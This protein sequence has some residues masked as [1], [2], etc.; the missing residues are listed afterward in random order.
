VYTDK[1]LS[2]AEQDRLL[3]SSD[4]IVLK[5]ANSS[6]ILL[7]EVTL[8]LHQVAEDLPPDKQKLLES[9]KHREEIFKGK[10]ILIA[11]DDMRNVYAL[12]SALLEKGST[13]YVG[14]T[15]IEALN[16]LKE[17]PDVDIVLMDIMMPEMDGFEAI[18]NIRE[19][20]HFEELPIIALTAKAMKGDREKC[21]EIG[22]TDYLSKP[23]DV[24]QLLSLL[25]VWIS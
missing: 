13:I 16:Q 1:E 11:D 25:R 21:L 23:I 4:T 12:R 17:H 2:N 15:G 9:I 14:K 19:I 20:K 18:K 10:K 6:D 3:K 24:H 7:D 22:A 5:R 8:F